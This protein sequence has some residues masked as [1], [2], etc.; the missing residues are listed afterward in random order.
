[1]LLLRA[2]FLAIRE[3]QQLRARRGRPYVEHGVR[4]V[5]SGNRRELGMGSDDV[6][7]ATTPRKLGL[8][9]S[10]AVVARHRRGGRIRRA[11][12]DTQFIVSY[13]Q[14]RLLRLEPLAMG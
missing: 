2:D 4:P 7:D 9:Y 5:S 10:I 11:A 6:P 8:G 3:S 14:S 1:M 13:Q 12:G